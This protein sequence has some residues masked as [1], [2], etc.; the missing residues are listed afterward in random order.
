M[1][2]RP[3]Q[4]PLDA[5]SLA[6]YELFTRITDCPCYVRD[7]TKIFQHRD[8]QELAVR[9]VPKVDI[10]TSDDSPVDLARTQIATGKTDGH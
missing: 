5:I 2:V 3:S 7:C 1:N 10:G 9:N 6:K 8:L 4:N